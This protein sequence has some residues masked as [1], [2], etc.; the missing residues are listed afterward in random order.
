MYVDKKSIIFQICPHDEVK[1][2]ENESFGNII[3]K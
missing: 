2:E 1:F 3:I